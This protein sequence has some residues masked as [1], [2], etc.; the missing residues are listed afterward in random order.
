MKD[1]ETADLY[2]ASAITILL[3]TPPA[4]RVEKGRTLF[5]F[6]ISDDLYK[7]MNAFNGGIPLNAYEYSLVIKRL[8]AEMLAR[9]GMEGVQR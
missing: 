3:N 1:F 6:P 2:L 5:V 7:A 9:R 8:R 4:F